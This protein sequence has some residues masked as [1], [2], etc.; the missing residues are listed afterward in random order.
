MGGLWGNLPNLIN[1]MRVARLR[2]PDGR[3]L[4]V[5]GTALGKARLGVDLS[6]EP[7]FSFKHKGRLEIFRG[8]DALAV[9][10]RLLPAINPSGGSKRA[11]AD[12]VQAIEARRGAE[13]YL[14]AWLR[15]KPGIDSVKAV[16]RQ[17]VM[18]R[19]ALEMALHEEAER[20][21]IEGELAMLEAAW[22]DAERIAAISDDL[23]MPQA[24]DQQLAELKTRNESESDPA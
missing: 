8:E 2:T 9:A 7:A 19:L 12:A 5:R 15:S 6:G 4:S 3:V 1:A 18:T 16:A 20:R 17:P 24:V 22:R 10:G 21:A 13:G 14:D 11:V 23:L